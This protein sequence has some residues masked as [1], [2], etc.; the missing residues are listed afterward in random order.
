MLCVLFFFFFVRKL[1][2]LFP[3]C[4][5][6]KKGQ[7]KSFK[8]NPKKNFFFARNSIFSRPS[9]LLYDLLIFYFLRIF[10]YLSINFFH[11]TEFS[12]VY[13]FCGQKWH[14]KNTLCLIS[15]FALWL[16]SL[17]DFLFFFSHKI[18][19]IILSGYIKKE[20]FYKVISHT[21]WLCDIKSHKS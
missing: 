17:N 2:L 19:I 16:D 12:A 3:C 14:F 20:G 7:K 21:N 10:L 8:C 15:S 18:W 9:T 1:K 4:R 13:I 11:S 5:H 6:S